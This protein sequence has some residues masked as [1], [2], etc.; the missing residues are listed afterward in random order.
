MSESKL[1]A[2]PTDQAEAAFLAAYRT[3]VIAGVL[4]L[5]VAGVLLL[6]YFRRPAEQPL[7]EQTY[8]AMQ[9]TV[10]A[11]RDPDVRFANDE[12]RNRELKERFDETVVAELQRLD[13]ESRRQYFRQK[14]FAYF[15][16]VLLAFAVAAM[17]IAGT[18]AASLK[19]RLP[20]PAPRSA[21]FDPLEAS[22]RGGLWAVTG[23]VAVLVAAVFALYVNSKSGITPKVIVQAQPK[24]E[25]KPE[26]SDGDEPIDEPA[27]V[28]APENGD[29]HPPT[30]NGESTD[31]NG[32]EDPH[33]SPYHPPQPTVDF[34]TPEEWAAN[35]PRFRGPN[36]SGHSAYDD[37]PTKWSESAGE[38]IRFK[39]AIPLPGHSS[40]VVW[41]K[42][43][44]VTGAVADRREVY[45][46]DADSGELK[47]TCEAK[48][49]PEST[50]E[51]A[52]TQAYTGFAACT[53]V[54]DGRR[55]YAMFANGDV[56]AVDYAGEEVW[57][58][59]LGLPVNA[60]GHAASLDMFEDK[61]F[62]LFDQGTRKD[63][64]SKLY[65]LDAATGETVWKVD[66]A[67]PN[68]W[69]TPLVVRSLTPPQLITAAEPWVIS[70]DPKNG[71]EIWRAEALKGG[72]IGPSPVYRN[73][74]VCVAN[75]FPGTALVKVD[76]KGDVSETHIAWENDLGAPDKCSP[77]VTDD[78]LLLVSYG[79]LTCFDAKGGDDPLWEYEFE[80]GEFTS[81]AGM[82]GGLMYQFGEIET[83]ETDEE[84]EP[85]MSSRCWILRPTREG[86]E[87]IGACDL[88]E[89]VVTSPAFQPGRI[90]IRG[91]K[92]IYG[93]G[94]S[95]E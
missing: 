2:E 74:S 90:Y 84:G 68:S 79:Y 29:D 48:G 11:V 66:R 71:D 24:T 65:A 16:A 8:I 58:R 51:P 22:A 78:L 28:D 61:L 91:H 25:E 50:A 60:Y 30:D 39:T 87:E 56:I 81:S 45:C 76:G 1:S 18:L 36:G 52:K 7:E 34:P 69:T 44:F 41:E 86:A 35:W 77:L 57:S 4:S 72:E 53:P 3:A 64:L 5:I 73:G 38:G 12:E 17:L 75:E 80:E 49:T 55:V 31:P 23:M 47:W 59:S 62:V 92:H 14:R 46:V 93:L 10:E 6:D 54:T 21:A 94:E 85:I 20:A 83:D 43:I 19:K 82:A 26:Q 63:D 37:N 15:G 89:G 70:Y 27:P 95:D 13:L 40:P 9:A 32:G 88:A 42:R 67:I 33:P